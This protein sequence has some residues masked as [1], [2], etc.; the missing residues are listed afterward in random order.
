MSLAPKKYPLEFPTL[1]GDCSDCSYAFDSTNLS[2][3]ILQ[4][5]TK[6]FHER[7]VDSHLVLSQIIS[8]INLVKHLIDP[9][10]LVLDALVA[11]YHVDRLPTHIIS[12]ILQIDQ[13]VDEPWPL[14]IFD[15]QGNKQKVYLNPGEML[16]YESAKLP[17]GRQFPLKGAYYD[18]AFIHFRI[19]GLTMDDYVNN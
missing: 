16:F 2:L 17:H 5:S 1:Q 10:D 6:I 12:A 18:N 9:A 8:G 4:L 15:H 11:R 19:Q 7:Y 13:K 14:T 3:A